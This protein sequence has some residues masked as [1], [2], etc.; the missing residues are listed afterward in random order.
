ME[1]VKWKWKGGVIDGRHFNYCKVKESE[2]NNRVAIDMLLIISRLGTLFNKHNL[3]GRV[4]PAA[5]CSLL[6]G[7]WKKWLSTSLYTTKARRTQTFTFT[8]PPHR[9]HS[10][11]NKEFLITPWKLCRTSN[12]PDHFSSTAGCSCFFFFSFPA[13]FSR[14]QYLQPYKISLTA[15]IG[16][17]RRPWAYLALDKAYFEQ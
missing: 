2:A 16:V 9:L 10:A 11:Y 12:I 5:T 3:S 4:L 14:H 7:V 15:L 17:G 13:L 1:H 8:N 6:I